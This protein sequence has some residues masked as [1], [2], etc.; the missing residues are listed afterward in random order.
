MHSFKRLA[1][2]VLVLGLSLAGCVITAA[3]IPNDI[4]PSATPAVY[5]YD[6]PLTVMARPECQGTDQVLYDAHPD[7]T[8]R[9][10]PGNYNPFSGEPP[11]MLERRQLSA[12]ELRTLNQLLDDL[13]IARKF[14][15][16]TPVPPGSPQTA[17][18]RTVLEYMLQVNG[19]TRTFDANGR[20]YVHTQAYRDA[21]ESLRL[22]LESLKSSFKLLP[23]Q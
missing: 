9:Y 23:A 6:L 14:E 3:P 16:S 2:L 8:F 20:A 4:E 11:A 5:N 21:L 19:T 12:G 10:Y 7:S 13:D 1:A 17:E 22:H 15:A 18:C